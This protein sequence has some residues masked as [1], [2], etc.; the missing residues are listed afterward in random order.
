M[1]RPVTADIR[2]LER[3][4]E[5]RK[6]VQRN[7]L[8]AQLCGVLQSKVNELQ[9]TKENSE[10]SLASS[11]A[12]FVDLQSQHRN[13]S[14]AHADLCSQHADL[15]REMAM[16]KAHK[17]QKSSRCKGKSPTATTMTAQPA[18]PLDW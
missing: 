12:D 17:T 9:Q 15:Q 13:L 3:G 7:E 6:S 8:D 10:R 1:T 18:L 2:K 5:R 11:R 4:R 16:L 14:R